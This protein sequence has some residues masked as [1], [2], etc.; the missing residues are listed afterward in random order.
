MIKREKHLSASLFFVVHIICFLSYL[1]SSCL[2]LLLLLL[3][4]G[5]IVLR[6][7]AEEAEVYA[8]IDAFLD[9]VG[10]LS[11]VV[12]LTMFEDEESFG[13]KHALLEYQVGEF[14]QAR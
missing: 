7:G 11:E 14:A 8:S 1:D 4:C 9:E 12:V 3:L 5:G 13:G 2:G 10:V 6:V